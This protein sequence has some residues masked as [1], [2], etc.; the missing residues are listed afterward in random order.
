MGFSVEGEG[1]VSTAL[2]HLR[3]L[4]GLGSMMSS[5]AESAPWEYAIAPYES[6]RFLGSQ[7]AYLAQL[8]TG[9]PRR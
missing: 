8:W 7:L 2:L 9:N 6:K 5:K 3:R 4:A 1:R